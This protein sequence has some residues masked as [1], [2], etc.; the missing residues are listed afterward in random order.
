[1][2]DRTVIENR[3]V[4][5]VDESGA[6]Y[7]SSHLV[8]E[9]LLVSGE[10]GVQGGE[11]ETADKDEVARELAGASERLTSQRKVESL[12]LEADG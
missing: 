3:A 6:K 12:G 5:T 10:P 8:A 4:A 1:M 11:L 2:S 7:A 9:P